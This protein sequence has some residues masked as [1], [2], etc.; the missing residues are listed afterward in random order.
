MKSKVREDVA[1]ELEEIKN[2]VEG[3]DMFEKKE[4]LVKPRDSLDTIADKLASG[5][6]D[7]VMQE[8]QKEV[9]DELKNEMKSLLMT[10][11]KERV[12]KKL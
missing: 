7:N 6:Y 4:V 2:K 9:Q 11:V 3:N 10:K 8:V 12:M 5:L 1:K